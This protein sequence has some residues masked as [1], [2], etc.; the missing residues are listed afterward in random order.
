MVAT[1]CTNVDQFVATFHRFC[2]DST[3]FVSTLAERPIG[4]ETAFSIQLEDKTPVLRGLCEVIKA[5][6]TPLNRFGRPGVRLAVR[7]LT[8]ES[9]VVFKMLQD[10]RIAAEAAPP[11]ALARTSTGRVGTEAPMTP[12]APPSAVAGIA[13]GS[14]PLGPALARLPL[15][16]A[17]QAPPTPRHDP[18]VSEAPSLPVYD[19]ASGPV[20]SPPLAFTPTVIPVPP[21]I[22]EAAT[23]EAIADADDMTNPVSVE[24]R[25]PGSS[26]VLP[27]NPLSNLTDQSLG[28]F[29]D[30]ALYEETGNF[31]RAPDY[32]DSLVDIEDPVASPPQAL[33]PVN[34]IRQNPSPAAPTLSPMAFAPAAPPDLQF[35]PEATPLPSPHRPSPRRYSEPLIEPGAVPYMPAPS[36]ASTGPVDSTAA[37]LA[38]SSPSRRRWILFG[39][40]AAIASSLLLVL[41]L[42]RGGDDDEPTPPPVKVA[43]VQPTKTDE[44]PREGPPG[45]TSDLT[46]PR[47]PGSSAT[48]GTGQIAPEPVAVVVPDETDDPSGPPVVGSGPC[49][50]TVS[51]TPAGSIVRIDDQTIGPSPITFNGPCKRSKVDVKHPRYALGTKIVNLTADQPTTIQI[52][53]ARPTHAVTIV[54]VPP[55]ATISIAGNRAGT[56]P[57]S[58]KLMGFTSVKL[59]VEKKGFKPVVQKVYSKVDGD[60]VM[61]KLVR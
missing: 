41:V 47:P 7:R 2:D 1:K 36:G 18:R 48:L 9:M 40:A 16:R 39:G 26:F 50:L 11:P 49:R 17:T 14:K 21:R 24:S 33:A 60:R 3:F 57:T 19:D 56:S 29:V 5:W 20:V 43:S 35:A 22:A 59:T 34:A 12:L 30:C 25:T 38:I 37:L 6:T 31:F 46:Q 8:N 32:E 27:A 45:Q 54:T 13:P 15:A 53:L 61:I 4:L 44:R 28:G 23:P 51:S 10:A 52:P 55:G 58:V 42:A